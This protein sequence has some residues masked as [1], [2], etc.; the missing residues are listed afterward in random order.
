MRT[1]MKAN[2]YA[3]FVTC[4]KGLEYL[5]ADEIKSL[6][7]EVEKVSPNGVYCHT[8]LKD[9][10][11]LALHSTLASRLLLAIG[12]GKATESKTLYQTGFTIN[13]PTFLANIKSL[14]IYFRGTSKSLRNEMYSAQVLKDSVVDK[15][16]ALDL[17]RPSI[18]KENPD[19]SLYAY[20]K[21]DKVK[22]YLD[23]VGYPLSQR[24]YRKKAGL[25]P[26]RE[27]LASAML[28]RSNYHKKDFS[29]YGLIDPCCGSGT[30]VI[31]AAMMAANL[32]PGL[33]RSDQKFKSWSEH[34]EPLWQSLRLKARQ[35]HLRAK[36]NLAP[37]MGYDIDTRMVALAKEN[38]KNAGVLELV[39]FKTQ[40]LNDFSIPSDLNA[41]LIITNPPFG[42][43]LN[44]KQ[45]LMPFYQRFGEKMQTYA[46]GFDITLLSSDRFLSKATQLKVQKSYKLQ[47]GP[48]ECE[49]LLYTLR[50]LL[51]NQESTTLNANA[52]M[53]KNRLL[54]NKKHLEKWLKKENI[55]AYRLYDKDLPEYAVA[56]DIY[57]DKALVQEYAPP[58]DIPL[59][60]AQNR[61]LQVFKVLQE[62]LG[63]SG[64]DILFKQRQKQ[65]GK[66]QYQKHAQTKQRMIV[67]E[68][69]IQCY[70][71]LHDYLDTGLFLDNRKLRTQFETVHTDS[72]LNLFCYTAV[73][74]LHAAFAG[75]KT[76]N[77]DLSKTYLSWAKDNFALNQFDLNY[78][79]FIHQD[80]FQFL[81]E[82][83]KFYQ[84]ILL[85]PPSFSNSKRM[86]QNLDIQR[87]HASLITLAM[88]RLKPEGKLFFVN[89]LK[90]FKLDETLKTCFDIKHITKESLDKD[91]QRP[92]V[93]HHAYLI[94]HQQK[95]S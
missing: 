36:K 38:A 52:L 33:I 39:Q 56:I 62:V 54:K 27:N 1:P 94:T 34:D 7:I 85:D 44:S 16:R 21:Y 2:H 5:L 89:N 57:N 4:G 61:L 90:T 8:T 32:A 6:D 35:K 42:E 31:E 11:Q 86:R 70:V 19:A 78:H 48:I 20:L 59:N 77:V 84:R 69:N 37:I 49:L 26:I 10:Y 9:I 25:A 22:I 41:G 50:P 18:D 12:E 88:E 71:N 67:S 80:V 87:D 72:F 75:A 17:S 3:L 76:T 74:S 15:Y 82:D 68:A 63:I 47:N 51:E 55:R 46:K 91:F 29:Q 24:G 95:S 13:W 65:K 30:I 83:Q 79:Q 58:K 53:L 40:A 93:I 60:K 81:K 23:L 92:K 28:I 73:A 45:E 43:R 66:S 64:K 14:S